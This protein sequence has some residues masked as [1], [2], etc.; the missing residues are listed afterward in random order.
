VEESF[1]VPKKGIVIRGRWDRVDEE[2]G[3][4]VILDYKSS[5]VKKQEDADRLTR[6]SL[7]LSIYAL[8]WKEKYGELPYRVELNFL[9]SGLVGSARR[10]EKDIA[11][12]WEKIRAAEEGIRRSKY[13]PKPSRK[14]C[15]YCSYNE[16]CPASAV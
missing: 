12:T 16:I 2:K 8:V 11:K 7:Q 14:V 6:Q 5:E 13:N 9:E 1:S 15:Q 3:E 4:S 10:D